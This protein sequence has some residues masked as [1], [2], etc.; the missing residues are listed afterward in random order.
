MKDTKVGIV[1]VVN[2]GSSFLGPVSSHPD[3]AVTALCDL[4]EQKLGQKADEQ[5]ASGHGR[6]QIFTDFETMLEGSGIDAVV[7]ATPMQLHVPMAI[8]ALQRGIHVLSEV[9]AAVS[10]DECRALVRAAAE[11]S[12]TYAMAENCCY[13]KSNLL[14][15]EI[16]KRGL[17]GQL[18][19]GEG[20][21]L[22]EL[23]GYNEITTWRRRWQTGVNGNT[24]PSHSL[25]PVLQWMGERI[26]S[27]CCAGSGHHYTDSQGRYY[28]QEDTTVTLCR[29]SGGGL[30]ALRL[31]ML[32]NRP[33]NMSYWSLQGTTGCF[34]TSRL[35]TDTAKI[36]LASRPECDQFTWIE[37]DALE[38]EFLPEKWRCQ[39]DEALASGHGG[40]DWVQSY[41]WID[42]ITAGRQPEIGVHEAMDMSLPGLMSTESI[43]SGSVWITVPDSREWG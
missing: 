2:R 20:E 32:S 39:S 34:E 42:A 33:H 24:Y 35:P 16:V 7:I 8:A 14:V 43:E 27:V 26:T 31:D 12:A 15:R 41:E 22:H 36:W 3:A 10:V 28:E 4:D 5:D 13:L 25:G 9:P 37:L 17:F 19:F 11:S 40:S 38:E 30:V 29:T 1:G 18:Y 23:K 6:P 21:Y